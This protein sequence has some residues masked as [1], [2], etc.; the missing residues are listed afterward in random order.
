MTRVLQAGLLVLCVI[1]CAPATTIAQ[2]NCTSHVDGTVPGRW[3]GHRVSFVGDGN[4]D[5]LPEFMA[6]SYYSNTPEDGHAYVVTGVTGGLVYDFKNVGGVDWNFFGFSVDGGMDID[7]DTYTDYVV[8]ALQGD[9]CILFL[10]D[11]GRME[12]F[13]GGDGTSHSWPCVEGYYLG[14]QFAC[15][16]DMIPDVDGDG[17]ADVAIGAKYTPDVGFARGRIYVYSPILDTVDVGGWPLVG[18]FREYTGLYDGGILGWT[19]AALGDVNG[20]GVPDIAGGAPVEFGLA[21]DTGRVYVF[22]GAASETILWTASGPSLNTHFGWDVA[23]AGDLDADGK[24]DVLIGEP[25]SGVGGVN[26]GRIWAYSGATGAYLWDAP[27]PQS[28]IQMGISVTSIGDISGDGIPDVA[29]GAPWWGGKGKV[30][31]FSGLDGSSIG[32]LTGDA[33]NEA[34][35]WDVASGDLDLDGKPDLM[36]SAVGYSSNLGRVYVFRTRECCPVLVTGDVNQDFVLTSADIIVIVNYVFKSGPVPD[37]CEAAAD[38]NCDGV[39]TSADIIYL[40]N[41]VFKGGPA[42]C[43]VCTLVPASWFCL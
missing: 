5:G 1:L 20:D 37:P 17:L 4:K 9:G 29:A 36:V 19:V 31:L 28:G 26:S 35:G 18:T 42:P 8:G 10:D 23:N 40:V 33:N 14:Q 32:D 34:F 27:G 24:D 21:T 43:D 39:V 3:Y 6:G 12:M 15:A 13:R 16:L 38:V 30:Y 11:P 2:Y 25:E 7:G 22:S 41:H